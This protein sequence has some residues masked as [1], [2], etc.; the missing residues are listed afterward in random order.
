VTPARW[1]A[2]MVLILAAVFAWTGG[3][4]SESNYLA[5]KRSEIEANRR[6]T[7]LKHEV[8][9]LQALRDSLEGNP[10]VQERVARELFGMMR[11]GEIVFTIVPDSAGLPVQGGKKP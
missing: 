5:L 11:P 10:A 4:F 8:D 2:I 9:S 1:I 7:R 3:T 6:L